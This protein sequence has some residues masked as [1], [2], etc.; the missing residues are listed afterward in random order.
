MKISENLT[1]VIPR[2]M[3]N[4]VNFYTAHLEEKLMEVKN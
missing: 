2:I 1:A 4:D 3:S